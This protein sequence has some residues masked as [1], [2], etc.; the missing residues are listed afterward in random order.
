MNPSLDYL[1]QYPVKQVLAQKDGNG[2]A[3]EFGGTGEGTGAI[4]GV[5]GT[6]EVPELADKALIVTVFSGT[7]TRMIFGNVDQAT[8]EIVDRT[9]VV[10]A[11]TDYF[12]IDPRFGGEAF[13][14]GRPVLEEDRPLTVAGQFQDGPDMP[15][16][17]APENVAERVTDDDMPDMPHGQ[18]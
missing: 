6:N 14:P 16:A 11:P 18:T 12:L 3:I 13:Y 7:E 15:D 5:E 2:Y 17:D 9:E 8:S 1:Y 10:V 4:I